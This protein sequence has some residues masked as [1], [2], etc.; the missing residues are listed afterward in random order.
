M[1]AAVQSP[2]I[3]ERLVLFTL[4]AVQVTHIL[5]Y[6]ILMPLG[7]S[8]MRVFDISAG[9]FS[10]LVAAYSLA[11]AITGFFGGFLM[12]RWDRKRSLLGLYA[13]FGLATLACAFAPTYEILLVARLAAGGF[14]G[15]A[16]AVVTAAVGDVVPAFRRGAAMGIVMTAF[17]IASALGVPVG[18]FIAS[19]SA[20]HAPFLFLAAL[21]V[22]IWFVAWRVLPDLPPHPEAAA[23]RQQMR[24][25][26][27]RPLHW[28]GFALSAMLVCG[29]GLVIPFMAPSMVT[30]VGL[31]ESQL[32]FVYAAGGA[33]A[34][35][36]MPWFGRLAD[37]HDKLRVFFG[38]S[39]G[40]ALAVLALTHLPAVPLLPALVASTAFMV[41]M[42][43][44]FPPAMA[45]ITN[46]VE[47]R[48]RGAFMSV[49]SAVQQAAGAL[50]NTAAGYVVTRDA[51]T[52][53]LHGYGR[54]GWLTVGAF[55][56][57]VWMAARLRSAAPHAS[58]PGG[59]LVPAAA[60]D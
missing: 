35:F 36:T 8:L 43:G 13:G 27:T 32:V 20:W 31:A 14:G 45:L 1:S 28:H 50:A 48:H 33:V 58:A 44:R 41:T 19:L 59:A 9:Q 34:F 22:P 23:P 3:R 52:G 21:S 2:Q 7:A 17:P 6:M 30:N 24:E 57:A 60:A 29:G 40:A 11:A 49:N 51:A 4:A 37:R 25:I 5:D 26:L 15:L 55:F 56:L 39:A 12:D 16:G 47:G 54:V 10:R 18:L 53:Y 46:A 42:S 38:V